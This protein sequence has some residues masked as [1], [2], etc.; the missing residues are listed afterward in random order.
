MPKK[1][2]P[3]TDPHG[4]LA[5]AKA[6][7]DA[8]KAAILTSIAEL[9]RTI[10]DQREEL[11]RL[12]GL[13]AHRATVAQRVEELVAELAKGAPDA[14]ALRD[15]YSIAR[16]LAETKAGVLLA[17]VMP[18]ALRTWLLAEL[19]ADAE[20]A[21]GWPTDDAADRRQRIEDLGLE[22]AE[23]EM[24]LRAAVLDARKAGIRIGDD[25]DDDRTAYP[26]AAGVYPG[27][28]HIPASPHVADPAEE[29]GVYDGPP[30]FGGQPLG[31]KASKLPSWAVPPGRAA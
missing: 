24:A 17:A 26:S 3:V 27:P 19:D 1:P 2:A 20:Q 21:G 29:P 22:L 7:F 4:Q 5:T 12:R 11:D 31:T 9:E 8:A 18:D 6:A 10:A 14:T 15:G 13:P 25:D 23:N 30:Q 28:P 16:H